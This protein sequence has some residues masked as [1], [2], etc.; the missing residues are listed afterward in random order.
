MK[1]SDDES[2]NV[3]QKPPLP[4]LLKDEEHYR[5]ILDLC[6]ALVSLQR[7]CDAIGIIKRLSCSSLSNEKKEEL[8]SL[9]IQ[10]AHISEDPKHG[11]DDVRRYVQ[12]HP[13]SSTAWHSYY[14]VASR[15]EYP[16]AKHLKFLHEVRETRKDCVPP[17]VITGHQFAMVRYQS[18]AREYLQAYK[19]QPDNALINLCVGTALIN[20]ALG[21]RLKNKHL[22][23]MQGIAFLNN[24]QRICHSSQEALYNIARAYHIVGLYTLAIAYYEKVLAIE[25]RDYPMAEPLENAN[26]PNKSGYCNLHNEAAYNLHLIYKKS[27]ALDLARQVLKSYCNP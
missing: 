26:V 3:Y 5:L 10:V 17:M 23:V 1:E 27:G 4:N 21:F 16:Y 15:L 7:Y 14:K 19:L 2:P 24:Y 20:L 6:K 8:Q 11:Y 9:G 13:Y 12:Q 22:C 18:A 25:E